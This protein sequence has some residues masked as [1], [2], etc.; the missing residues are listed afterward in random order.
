MGRWTAKTTV[1]ALPADVLAHLHGTLIAWGDMHAYSTE[2]EA[3]RDLANAWRA[4]SAWSA[5]GVEIRTAS[6][7]ASSKSWRQSENAAAPGINFAAAVLLA[8]I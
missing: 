5:G 8:S 1:T 6:T 2:D 3:Y 7:C 4:Q